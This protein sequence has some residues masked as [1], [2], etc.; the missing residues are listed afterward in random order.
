MAEVDRD[1]V[2]GVEEVA[3]LRAVG[4]ERPHTREKEVVAL[5][6]AHLPAAETQ[7]QTC[8]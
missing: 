8:S 3:A 7:R 4:Q 1:G 5:V 2:R 6:P